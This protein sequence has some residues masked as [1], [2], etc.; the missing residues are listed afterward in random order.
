MSD[1][2]IR[3]MIVDD[4]RMVRHGLKTFLAGQ[5]DL[6]IVAEAGDGHEAV[7][8]TGQAQPDVILMDV[9][10]PTMD[11]PTATAKIRQAFPHIQIIALTTFLEPELVESALKSGAI[12]YLLKDVGAAR[13]ADAIRAAARGQPT[14]DSSAAH[15]LVPR[16]GQP[17]PVGEDLTGRERDILALLVRGLTNKQIATELH[18]SPG[19]VRIYVSQIL[20]KLGVSNRTEAAALALQHQL[21]PPS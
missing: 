2:P 19:T 7:E 14:I 3:V 1:K 6:L 5:K 12:G 21:V 8:R 16:A 10:M 11:G 4:H 17:S 20:T 9:V 15:L 18:L 13:L